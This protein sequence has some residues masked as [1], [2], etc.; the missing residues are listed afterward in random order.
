MKSVRVAL[1]VGAT[2]SLL[3]GC[4]R[5][6]DSAASPFTPPPSGEFENEGTE[7]PTTTPDRRKT[8]PCIDATPGVVT[9]CIEPTAGIAALG[10]A[11]SALVAERR[12]G[13]VLMSHVSDQKAREVLKLDVDGAGDGGLLDVAPSPTFAQDELIFAYVTT[14]SDNRVVRVA[15]GDVPKPILTGIPKGPNGNAGAIE[16]GPKGELY[17]L[18]GNAG[19]PAAAA[20]PASLAGKLLRI[21]SPR[22]GANPQPR[23]LLSGLG[24]AGDVC[25]RGDG[26]AW[27]TDRLPTE[28]RLQRVNA[29]GRVVSPVWTWP[30]RPGVAGCAAGDNAVAVALTAG[31]ALAVLQLDQSGAVTAQPTLTAHEMY[32]QLN[33]AS[34]A[35]DGA[36]WVGTVNKTG[37]QPGPNDDRVVRITVS[38]GG[39]GGPD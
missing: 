26:S 17:V 34:L 32:G 6:D 33:G 27:V 37:P 25:L 4:A 2:V 3:A 20:N 8:G 18:T 5:V 22:V 21:D 12:T 23:V 29:D 10:D 9:T 31:R 16:F 15:K 36:V 28:D 30:D 38:P 24:T 7:P 39:G 35:P 19:D 14:G 11:E 1:A 13:R